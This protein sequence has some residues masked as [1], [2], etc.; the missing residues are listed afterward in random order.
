MTTKR[1]SKIFELI[2]IIF[3]PSR[4]S[5]ETIESLDSLGLIY[6]QGD[7]KVFSEYMK[8]LMIFYLEPKIRD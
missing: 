3:D 5:K 4:L 7:E 6:N 1:L 8:K 2:E